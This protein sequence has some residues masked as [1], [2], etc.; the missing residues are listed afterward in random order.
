MS[1][2]PV[3]PRTLLAQWVREQG[4]TL[5]DFRHRYADA[6]QRI[7]ARADTVSE[8]Q[9]KRW[10]AGTVDRPHPSASAV[11]EALCQRPI[12]DLM[13]PPR[14]AGTTSG[15]PTADEP[16]FAGGHRG[17]TPSPVFPF[18]P[19][20][21][22]AGND[23]DETLRFLARAEQAPAPEMVALL[24]V[25]VQQFARSYGDRLSAHVEEMI[26]T[27]RAAFRLLDGPAEPRQARE[28]YLLAG[29]VCAMLAHASRDLGDTRQAIIY[30]DA[31]LLCAER[32]G[33]LGLRVVVRTEQAA[34]AYW[35]KDF[36]RSIHY[37]DLAALDA[38]RVRG[39]IAVLPFV[40]QARAYAAIG[41][42]SRSR[43]AL[44]RSHRIRDHVEPDD[45]DDIGGLMRFSL[46][47]QLG[48]IAGTAA[49]YP[50]PTESERAAH[51][52]VTAYQDAPYIDR[53]HNSEAIARADLAIARVR[54]HALDGAEDALRSVLS[55]PESHRVL[56]IRKG[57]QRVRALLHADPFYRS[58]PEGRRLRKAADEF[59]CS[60]ESSQE[61]R[62]VGND[63]AAEH[64]PD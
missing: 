38:E 55:I 18:G 21:H 32:S 49:W 51:D 3:E 20:E 34:T 52:A 6:A 60:S 25:Q 7:G 43:H 56:P 48:I 1:S 29:L 22:S 2:V 31:G 62:A 8:R 17:E 46:P 9:A 33:H 16:V 54:L 35:M 58:A 24:W 63:A 19:P 61:L 57:V 28:I 4:W 64:L 41:D 14:M 30:Q 59:A 50:D 36:T 44:T 47:E 12:G 40:Q 37:T 11:L 23:A 26:V 39:S 10:F 45:L 42:T 13:S 5:D 27:R 53:S 15:S